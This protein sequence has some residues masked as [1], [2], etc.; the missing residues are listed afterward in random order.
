MFCLPLARARCEPTIIGN[1]IHFCFN[2]EA[3][4][5]YAV[6][7]RNALGTGQWITLASYSGSVSNLTA[8]GVSDVVTGGSRFYRVRSP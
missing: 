8:I 2:A 4:S 3:G 1:R 6:E 5:N 7:Y